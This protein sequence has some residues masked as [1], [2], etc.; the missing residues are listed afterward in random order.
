M[1]TQPQL[2]IVSFSSPL[3]LTQNLTFSHILFLTKVVCLTVKQ[4]LHHT[5]KHYD[6]NDN[7]MLANCRRFWRSTSSIKSDTL[8]A[9][10]AGP[11]GSHCG[12]ELWQI[13]DNWRWSTLTFFQD[14]SE[15]SGDN[16]EVPIGPLLCWIPRG[17]GS[18]LEAVLTTPTV[19]LRYCSLTDARPRKTISINSHIEKSDLK[20]PNK[21]LQSSPS[22]TNAD[23][24]SHHSQPMILTNYIHPMSALFLDD[25]M[26][27]SL[28]TLLHVR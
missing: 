14:V 12:A 27:S 25:V 9:A 16:S 26:M 11:D 5:T 4:I 8:Q 13:R 7:L 20:I 2:A 21:T 17:Q 10:P 22:C 19:L 24:F 1:A 23:F 28:L 15:A 18:G 3:P 6:T